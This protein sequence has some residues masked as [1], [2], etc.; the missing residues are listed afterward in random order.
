M[1]LEG[2]EVEMS[3]TDHSRWLMEIVCRS[4][5]VALVD[6][7]T[8]ILPYFAHC[9]L[10]V[11]GTCASGLYSVRAATF[12]KLEQTCG[13]RAAQWQTGLLRRC[14]SAGGFCMAIS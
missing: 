14:K 12:P 9:H 10:G 11:V 7:N 1:R 2:A 6:L 8:E 3:R 5:T 4:Q 13:A